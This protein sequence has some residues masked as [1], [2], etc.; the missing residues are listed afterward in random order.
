MK[1][2]IVTHRRE[3]YVGP[4]IYEAKCRA[5]P[6]SNTEPYR[7]YGPTPEAARKK[8]VDI[9]QQCLNDFYELEVTELELEPRDHNR[10]WVRDS[11][12]PIG[13]PFVVRLRGDLAPASYFAF[14]RG[15]YEEFEKKVASFPK[16]MGWDWKLI[17]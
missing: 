15:D 5:F 3:H 6:W 12:P 11:K 2:E 16:H 4:D 10:G 1:F 8:I 9:I 7:Q 17:D 14:S 13:V